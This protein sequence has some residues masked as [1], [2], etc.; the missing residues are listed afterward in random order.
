MGFPIAGTK[1]SIPVFSTLLTHFPTEEDVKTG[2]GK[3]KEELSRLEPMIHSNLKHGF[4][5]LNELFT[6]ATSYDAEIM[7]KQVLQSFMKKHFLGIYVTHM[8]ELAQTWDT[9]IVSII[10]LV[11]K[12]EKT[13]TY[14]I[15]RD[16]PKG[17]AYAQT[18]AE[19]YRLRY[20]DILKRV[21]K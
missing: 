21:K 8:Q 9:G 6:T 14:H 13:R 10:A 18:I 1:A 19:K 20:E 2:S 12:D 15:V 3:L 17:I 4:V 11:D 16:K 5:I 7:G